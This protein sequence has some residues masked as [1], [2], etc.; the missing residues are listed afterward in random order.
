MSPL[1]VNKVSLGSES[2]PAEPAQEG[3]L[4]G[5]RPDVVSETGALRKFT[6][7]PQVVADERPV[8]VVDP[9]VARQGRLAVEFLVATLMLALVFTFFVGLC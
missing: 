7:A 4:P 8:A 6:L 3:L 9:L 2:P 5:V 1:M